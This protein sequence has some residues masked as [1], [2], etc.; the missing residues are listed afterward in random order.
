MNTIRRHIH[1][2]AFAFRV[3]RQC[4]R[5]ELRQGELEF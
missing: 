4:Y 5:N 1:A 3:A 2:L